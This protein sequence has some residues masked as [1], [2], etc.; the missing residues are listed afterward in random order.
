MEGTIYARG[1]GIRSCSRGGG[2]NRLAPWV[3]DKDWVTSEEDDET[4]VSRN[5]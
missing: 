2:R 1:K 5:S 3:R 4:S